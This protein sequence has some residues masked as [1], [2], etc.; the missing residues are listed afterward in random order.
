MIV[1]FLRNLLMTRLD[2]TQIGALLR[3]FKLVTED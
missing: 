2:K 3:E 1:R